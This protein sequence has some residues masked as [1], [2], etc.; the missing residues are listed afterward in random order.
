MNSIEECVD[1]QNV[2]SVVSRGRPWNLS[3]VRVQSIKR[4]FYPCINFEVEESREYR[5]VVMKQQNL[6]ESV[7]KLSTRDI[8][9]SRLLAT[10][11][12]KLYYLRPRKFKETDAVCL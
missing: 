4:I 10:N 1:D 12:M 3:C 11:R 6:K 8:G 9:I 2:V 7:N 5:A